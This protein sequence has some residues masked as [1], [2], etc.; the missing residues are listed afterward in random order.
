[1]TILDKLKAIAEQVEGFHFYYDVKAMQNV[2]ADNAGFPAIWVEEY[3][4]QR[5]L[6]GPY[7]R[8]REVTLEIHFSQLVPFEG[9][10]EERERTRE[11][12][13]EYGVYPFLDAM[14]ASGFFSEVMEYQCD[15]EP[16]MFDANVTGVLLRFTCTIPTCMISIETETQQ[17]N[18]ETDGV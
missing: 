10:A 15:P 9:V 2:T 17:S 11:Y 13:I 7:N 16:P 12:L 3:Y 5:L 8:K 4:A 6:K 18:G 14:D 1:M